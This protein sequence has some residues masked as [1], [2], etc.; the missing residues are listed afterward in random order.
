MQREADASYWS[1]LQLAASKD[2]GSM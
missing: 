1:M 2:T